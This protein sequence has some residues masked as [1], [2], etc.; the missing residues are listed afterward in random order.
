MTV[1][2]IG[3]WPNTITIIRLISSAL[4]KIKIIWIGLLASGRSSPEPELQVALNSSSGQ[5]EYIVV[6]L[7]S[8]GVIL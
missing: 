2:T 4:P 8:M 5:L 1:S 3:M 7:E 6:Y